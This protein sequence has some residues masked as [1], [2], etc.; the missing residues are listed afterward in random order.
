MIV[1]WTGTGTTAPFSTLTASGLTINLSNA[2]FGTGVIR[3]GQESIDITTLAATPSI[4]SAAP[5]PP[6]SPGLS[7]LLLPLFS[8]GNTV[9]G[10][11]SFNTLA[12]YVTQLNTTLA[13]VPALK[14][15]AGGVYNRAT[16]IFTATTIN[17]VL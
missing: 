6:P 4:V 8:V 1:T 10:I 7:A 16:N 2:S 15:T 17:V 14:F 13:T 9:A 12:A 3:I 5:I 11:S